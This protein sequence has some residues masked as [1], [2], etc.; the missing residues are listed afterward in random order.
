MIKKKNIKLNIGASPI[1][2]KED[3]MILDHKASNNTEKYIKG[4]ADNIEI[5]DGVCSLLFCSHVVEHIP[6]F[7]IQKIL[8]EFSR[9]LELGG[10]IRLLTPDLRK[11][12]KAYVE[13]DEKYFSE[14]LAEDENIRKDLGIGGMFMNF[15][16]SPGQDTILLNRNMTEFVGGY[17]HVYTY[18]FEMLRILFSQMGFGNIKQQ[19]FCKSSVAELEEPLHVEGFE[20]KWQ[21]L[22]RKFYTDNGLIHKYKDGKYD[23]NFSLTGFD[24][25]PL[26]SLIVEAVKEKNVTF[27]NVVDINGENALNYNRYGFSLLYDEEVKRKLKLLNIT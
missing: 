25:D 4:D 26:T 19:E 15:V 23:I 22:N 1:W 8:L 14:A 20:K 27:E 7:K 16:I 24:R 2:R 6:H 3:W 13:N 12:A 17:A 18:D 11:I 9:V 21:N 5:D 10:V